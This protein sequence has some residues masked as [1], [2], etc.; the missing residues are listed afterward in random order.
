LPKYNTVV[1]VNGC[2]WHGHTCKRGK[3]PAT[4]REF[5]LDKI[6]KNINRD[7]QNYSTLRE[8]GWH[9]VIVWSCETLSLM[10]LTELGHRLAREIGANGPDAI[11]TENGASSRSGAASP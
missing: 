3:L 4:N 10:N 5:W 1:F 2:F 11:T 6:T 9:V 7:H 8:Q